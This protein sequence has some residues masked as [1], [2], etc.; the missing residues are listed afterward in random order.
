M[1]TREPTQ[2]TVNVAINIRPLVATDLPSLEW[3][4]QYTHFRRMYKRTF[5]DQ[6]AGKRLMLV[7]DLNGY[8]VGQVFLHLNLRYNSDGQERGY[9]YSLRVMDHLQ[10][11]G[12]GTRLIRYAEQEL[13]QRGFDWTLIS[14][15]KT[16]PRARQLYERLGYRMYGEDDGR[17]KYTNHLGEVVHMHEP[18]WLLEKSLR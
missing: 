4:G 6:L 15:A 14:A 10:G 8:A 2:F 3:Y 18:C 16:N 1:I 9:L 11:M 13:A 5:Q 17:W 12:I 7:A